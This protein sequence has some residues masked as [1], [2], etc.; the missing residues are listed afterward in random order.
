MNVALYAGMFKENHDGAT[1]TLYRLV[2]TMISEGIHTGVWSFS[3]LPDSHPPLLHFQ[4]PSIPLPLFPDYRVSLPFGRIKAQLDNFKP[5]LIHVSV[6]D[7]MGLFLLKYA[8]QNGVPLVAS[9]HTNFPSYLDSFHL[10]F[11]KKTLWEWIAWFF[12]QCELVYAPTRLAA[13]ELR[14]HGVQQVRIWS[15]GIDTDDFHPCFRCNRLRQAWNAQR[16][17]VIIFCG[18]LV[19]YKGLDAF[20]EVYS[21]FQKTAANTARFVVIGD[22]PLRKSLQQE[23]PEAVFTGFLEGRSLGQAYASSD[24][25]LF[26]ST[27][28]TFGNVALEAAASGIPSVVSDIGGPREIIEESKSGLI[29]RAGDPEDYY[30]KCLMILNNPQISSRM[31]RNGLEYADKKTWN[32][33]NGV[34]ISDYK[35][36]LESGR[37][38]TGWPISC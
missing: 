34:V 19:P 28:E 12:N 35:N 4:L 18:R 32:R 1:R 9:Y 36:L 7:L 24:L 29:A 33:I 20:A 14:F 17:P 10:Q 23:M 5:D 15:R 8:Q 13:D 37:R 3:K 27:T 22:G 21:L 2:E 26:P 6:P 31:R 25:L 16:L 38:D 11:L 30:R